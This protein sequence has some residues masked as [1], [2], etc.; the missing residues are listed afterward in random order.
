MASLPP[1]LTL[2]ISNLNSFVTVKLDSTNYI[3]WKTHLQ[4][5]LRATNLLCYVDGTCACPSATITDS[6][7]KNVINPEFLSWTQIDAHLLSCITATL[8]PTMFT[9]VFHCKSCQE[10]WTYLDKRFTSLSRSHIHQLKNKLSSIMKKSDLADQLALAVSPIEDEDLVLITLNGLPSEY[11]ALKVAIRARSE[12]ITMEDLAFLLCSEALHIEAD[13]KSS[14]SDLIVAYTATQHETSNQSSSYQAGSRGN[15]SSY[16]GSSHKGGASVS[17]SAPSVQSYAPSV[18][19]F[20]TPVQSPVAPSQP[21]AIQSTAA[22]QPP[23]AATV[24]PSLPASALS[25]S[26]AVPTSIPISSLTI[27]LP[28]VQPISATSSHSSLNIH[29]MTTRSRS[30]SS[31][32][33]STISPLIE[34][35]CFSEPVL[36][37]EWSKAM[38]EEFQALQDQDTWSL[39]PLPSHKQAI[40]CKWV[41]RLKKNSDGSIA[42]HKARLVAKGYLQQEGINYHETF[43][44]VAKQ[45]TVRVLLSI[46][47]HFNWSIKQLDISNAFLHGL[48]QEEV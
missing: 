40:G 11:N 25:P 6:E 10:I 38:Q 31:A 4:N 20:P 36:T 2:L 48:L 3:V 15:R 17:P 12:A 21:A 43:S 46:A 39:V 33:I 47:L 24:L 26:S 9:S 28:F 45:P 19:P 34:P 32:L 30:S 23:A 7:G 35:A 8:T 5:I 37:P 41:F 29:P 18:S 13:H 1:N 27:D 16:R 14:S 44:P 42:R 22:R